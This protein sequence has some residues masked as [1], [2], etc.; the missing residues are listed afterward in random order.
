MRILVEFFGFKELKG[1]KSK[2]KA[3]SFIVDILCLIFVTYFLLLVVN[4]TYIPFSN[5]LYF[6]K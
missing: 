5:L 1:F 4:P 2:E 3:W 6:I